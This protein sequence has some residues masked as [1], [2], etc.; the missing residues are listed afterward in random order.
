LKVGHKQH[1]LPA[2]LSGSAVNIEKEVS[3]A[4]NNYTAFTLKQAQ[5][6][7]DHHLF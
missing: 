3:I 1:T 7:H 5:Q 2:R 6:H 4:Q